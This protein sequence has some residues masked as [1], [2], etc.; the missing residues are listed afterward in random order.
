MSDNRS[1][2][3]RSDRIMAQE[4]D[5]HAPNYSPAG[6]GR[7]QGGNRSRGSLSSGGGRGQ[8][9]APQQG[10]PSA[11]GNGPGSNYGSQQG[12]NSG[13]R[14]GSN[15]GSRPGSNAGSP[16][17]SDSGR[18]TRANTPVGGAARSM[19]QVPGDRRMYPHLP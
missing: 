5:G 16:R 6:R 12:S 18:D 7:G 3:R 13:S 19:S 1:S 15:T 8:G 17:G 2:Q 10:S 14:P 11:A 4:R 9:G